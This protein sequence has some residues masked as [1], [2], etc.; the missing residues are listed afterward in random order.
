M[1]REERGCF[2]L[3]SRFCAFATQHIRRQTDDEEIVEQDGDG[4]YWLQSKK[5]KGGGERRQKSYTQR[6]KGKAKESP[7]DDSCGRYRTRKCCKNVSAAILKAAT[8]N[9]T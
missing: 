2:Q 4:F 8:I 5:Q 9:M 3:W 1:N 6:E 7:C